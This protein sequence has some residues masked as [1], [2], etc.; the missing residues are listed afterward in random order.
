MAFIFNP[1]SL[2]QR[3]TSE[4]DAKK[5]VEERGWV[6]VDEANRL[7][8]IYN[9]AS[10]DN[11]MVLE[12]DVAVWESKGYY[13]EPTWVYSPDEG[14]RMVSA[15]EAGTMLGRGWYESPAD[16]SKASTEAIV[17]KAVKAKKQK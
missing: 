6:R 9:P 2:E 4:A 5:A 12:R 10:A 13:A 11:K 1:N 7:V 16:F 8:A 17:D 3:E 15:A 14:A